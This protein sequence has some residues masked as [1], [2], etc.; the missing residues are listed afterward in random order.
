MFVIPL[1][2][3]DI[4]VRQSRLNRT[5]GLRKFSGGVIP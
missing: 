5:D 1:V 3:A 2:L 4:V